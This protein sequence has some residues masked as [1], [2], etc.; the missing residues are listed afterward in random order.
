[1]NLNT[2]LQLHRLAFAGDAE[3]MARHLGLTH[4]SDIDSPDHRGN[5]PLLLAL[6]RG[7]VTT[8]KVLLTWQ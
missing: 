3:G 2:H 1:M 6:R 4:C 5:S 7:H 8:A